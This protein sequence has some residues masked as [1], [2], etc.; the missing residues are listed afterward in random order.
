MH[1]SAM[2]R[3]KENASFF[4]ENSG[5]PASLSLSVSTLVDAPSL[6][7]AASQPTLGIVGDIT[8]LSAK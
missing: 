1:F 5:N 3:C 7:S 4:S 8:H 6:K 2:S